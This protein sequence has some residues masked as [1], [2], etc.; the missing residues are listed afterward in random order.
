MLSDT[1]VTLFEREVEDYRENVRMGNIDPSYGYFPT[2]RSLA[3]SLLQA[4]E[5]IATRWLGGEDEGDY[6]GAYAGLI[7]LLQFV[8]EMANRDTPLA[9][10]V[11]EHYVMLRNKE[12][13]S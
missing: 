9:E 13:I 7:D 8:A 2:V 10:L 12:E 4:P 6:E 11:D 3:D 1:L 5:D